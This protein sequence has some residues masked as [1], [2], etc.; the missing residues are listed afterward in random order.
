MTYRL[1]DRVSVCLLAG[2]AVFLDA[3]RDRYFCVGGAAAKAVETL[4]EQGLAHEAELAGLTK[5]GLIEVGEGSQAQRPCQPNAP[6]RSLVED[7]DVRPT[8]CIGD[9]LEVAARLVAAR[10]DVRRRPFASI[11]DDLGST[12]AARK[13]LGNASPDPRLIVA[14]AFNGARRL[15]PV[16]PQCLPDS[17]ALLAFLAR[18]GC[19]ADLVFG[20]KLRPFSAHC[21]VQTGEVVLNDAL[22]HATIHTPIL[23]V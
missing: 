19:S 10:R 17:L 8:G 7:P 2:Q 21:W 23:V 5:T 14:A 4:L 11:L 13:A 9:Y 18:R 6:V 1:S 15:V 20:V 16:K 3:R 22:D 12:K